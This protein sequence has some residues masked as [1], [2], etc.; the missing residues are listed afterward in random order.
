MALP[1]PEAVFCSKQWHHYLW[2]PLQWSYDTKKK[3]GE[4]KHRQAGIMGKTSNKSCQC[5][6]FYK[7]GSEKKGGREQREGMAEV[8]TWL[9][10]L[11]GWHR[12]G[13]EGW[14]WDKDVEKQSRGLGNYRDRQRHSEAVIAHSNWHIWCANDSVTITVGHQCVAAGFLPTNTV[15]PGCRAREDLLWKSGE[16][17]WQNQ[18][19]EAS[20]SLLEISCW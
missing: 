10:G 2:H 18:K 20:L 6:A 11:P 7:G 4:N 12:G 9:P 19:G 8:V 16:R 13:S 14:V 3:G 17:F 15:K 1:L 5:Y